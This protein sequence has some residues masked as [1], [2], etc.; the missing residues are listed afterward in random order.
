MK[1][2]K[3][4]SHSRDC[5][6]VKF[7]DSDGTETVLTEFSMGY[8]PYGLNLGGG[9]DLQFEVDI[10]TGQILNWDAV[11]VNARIETMIEEQKYDL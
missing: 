2:L 9:D 4:Y 8:V 3:I 6:D 10:T 7:V 11:K 5:N 1:I